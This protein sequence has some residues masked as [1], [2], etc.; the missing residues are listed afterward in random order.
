MSC[1]SV[2]EKLSPYLDG[3]LEAGEAR[4]VSAHLEACGGCGSHWRSLRE[5]LRTLRALPVLSPAES[6]VPRVMTRVEVESRGPGLALLFRPTW[7]ARPLIVPSLVSAALVF[8]GALAGAILLDAAPRRVQD[9]FTLGRGID[10]SPLVLLELAAPRLQAP[11]LADDFVPSRED[12]HFFETVVTR[13]G[14]VAEVTLLD[15]RA[16]DAGRMMNALLRERFEPA[17]YRGRPV[18][19][20]VYRLISRLDVHAPET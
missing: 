3:D 18:A 11:A 2:R 17:R 7:K 13:D 5:A 10:G 15:G 12:S 9:R 19:V 6:L 16:A 20:N 1:D 14:R 8:V 4:Q